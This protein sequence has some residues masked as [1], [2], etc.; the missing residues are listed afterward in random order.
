MIKMRVIVDPERNLQKP[1][2]DKERGEAGHVRGLGARSPVVP[3]W[4]TILLC[5]S[6]RCQVC[7]GPRAGRGFRR[8]SSRGASPRPLWLTTPG[9]RKVI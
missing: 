6:G 9:S 3:E 2:T 7:P 1:N 8:V 4:R 5:P